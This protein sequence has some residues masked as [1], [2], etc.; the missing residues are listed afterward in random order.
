MGVPIQSRSAP[1]RGLH[2]RGWQRRLRISEVLLS[3]HRM[4][5]EPTSWHS[6]VHQVAQ[7]VGAE[8]ALVFSPTEHSASIPGV[9]LELD[10]DILR[11]YATRWHSHDIWT[12]R[13][14]AANALSSP[15][16]LLGEEFVPHEEFIAST[17]YN[18]CLGKNGV[19]RLMTSAVVPTGRFAQVPHIVCSLY[20]RPDR[21]AFQAE[22]QR[23]YRL[24]LP[25]F[26]HA[27]EAFWHWRM[28]NAREA[29]WRGA[30]EEIGAAVIMLGADQKILVHS[31]A[32]ESMFATHPLLQVR[33]GRL[34]A[35]GPR[36]NTLA[37]SA[38]LVA[39]T[40]G[41]T[42]TVRLVDDHGRI[43]LVVNASSPP[44]AV[45]DGMHGGRAS[46]V[47]L[48]R[49]AER[50]NGSIAAAMRATFSLTE[51]EAR[52]VEHLLDGYSPARIA[53]EL[54]RAVGT[55]RIHLKRVYWKTGVGGQRELLSL[56]GRFRQSV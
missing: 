19:G 23:R 16:I 2:R 39:A 29:L 5:L 11:E 6:A 35:R 28:S 3:V 13:I 52:V 12:A 43:K 41:R 4:A 10:P 48:I 30:V 51:T 46:A 42:M 50:E 9:T 14:N 54:S 15:R 36:A 18:E 47:L 40:G 26:V 34:I 49:P 8:K 44:A 55:I 25:H 20:R 45:R 53:Q 38:A 31:P 21:G 32:A 22:S 27:M 17:V 24:V 56:A 33:A 37:L 7:L 1:G